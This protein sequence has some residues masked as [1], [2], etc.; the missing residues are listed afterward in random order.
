MESKENKE[1]EEW[2]HFMEAVSMLTE[3][4]SDSTEEAPKELWVGFSLA[5]SM[6]SLP[7]WLFGLEVHVDERRAWSLEVK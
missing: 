5:A 7:V 6:D 2:S 4:F 3:A 1:R